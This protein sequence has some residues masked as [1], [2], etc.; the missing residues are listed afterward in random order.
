MSLSTSSFALNVL[1]VPKGNNALT[2]FVYAHVEQ[3][4]TTKHEGLC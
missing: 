1:K 4:M 3:N 2:S